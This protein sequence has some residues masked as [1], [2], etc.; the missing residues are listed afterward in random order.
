[1]SLGTGL[2]NLDKGTSLAKPALVNFS[3][4]RHSLSLPAARV[5]RRQVIER[6]PAWECNQGRF[7]Q[8]LQHFVKNLRAISPT[9]RFITV[10]LRKLRLRTAGAKERDDIECSPEVL[11]WRT[12]PNRAPEARSRASVL[13]EYEG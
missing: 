7:P 5:I 2:L 11:S 12:R 4:S 8:T 13:A 9:L 10:Q 6:R 3:W 1:M